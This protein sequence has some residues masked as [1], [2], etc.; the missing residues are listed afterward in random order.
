MDCPFDYNL[1]QQIYCLSFASNIVSG[2]EGSEKDLEKRMKEALNKVLPCLPGDWVISWGPRVFKKDDPNSSCGPPDNVWFAAVSEAQKTCVTAIAGTAHGST[3]AI[4]QDLDVYKVVDFNAW[5][6]E[7]SPSEIPKPQ[8]SDSCEIDDSTVAYC[9]EGTCIGVWNIL[10][11]T[12]EAAGEVMRIDQYLSRLDTSYKIVLTGH[13]LGG[14]LSPIVALGLYTA[15]MIGTHDVKVLPSA[16][17]SPGNGKLESD[18]ATSFPKC[19]PSAKDYK[20]YNT[21]YY[22]EFDIVPQAWSIHFVTDDRNLSKILR[23]ILHF[24]ECAGKLPKKLVELAEYISWKSNIRYKPL[25]GQ[26]FTGPQPPEEIG[27]WDEA[28]E[29]VSTE[30]NQAYWDEIGIIEFVNLFQRRL[31]SGDGEAGK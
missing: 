30:H 4:I 27:S 2:F 25:P 17:V 26:K 22:N 3:A 11:N 8:A 24:E 29:I 31:R 7:W 19:P 5:V 20:V 9:A 15:D 12:S 18:Y 28:M 14:A 1:F 23:K 6:E 16:G 21:D 10:S 13:S